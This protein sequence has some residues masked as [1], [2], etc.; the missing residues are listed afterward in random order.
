MKK[1]GADSGRIGGSYK[2][3]S[4]GFKSPAPDHNFLIGGGATVAHQYN[5]RLTTTCPSLSNPLRKGCR[6][7]VTTGTGDE[8]ST[9]SR[10]SFVL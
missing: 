9:P 10:R 6:R 2:A 4:A 1:T 5:Y 7:M 3:T 8:G